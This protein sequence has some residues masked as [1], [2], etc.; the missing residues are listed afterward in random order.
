MFIYKRFSL[1]FA[2]EFSKIVHIYLESCIRTF[3]LSHIIYVFSQSLQIIRLHYYKRAI[4]EYNHGAPSIINAK[5]IGKRENN[6]IIMG[7]SKTLVYKMRALIGKTT[8]D[9]SCK[10]TISLNNDCFVLVS[11]Y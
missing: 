5:L 1:I 10:H 11:S 9:Q 3:Y 6:E 7:R 4:Y 2:K 8:N